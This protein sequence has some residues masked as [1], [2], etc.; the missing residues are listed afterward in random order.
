ML[1]SQTKYSCNTHSDLTRYLFF[2]SDPF[3][4]NFFL[5]PEKVAIVQIQSWVDSWQE[6]SLGL[7]AWIC[8]ARLRR[9]HVSNCTWVWPRSPFD[10]Y[11]TEKTDSSDSSNEDSTA[12]TLKEEIESIFAGTPEPSHRSCCFHL[13]Q[14]R[15]SQTCALFHAGPRFQEEPNNLQVVLWQP[16][17]LQVW[18]RE[19]TD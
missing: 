17:P 5:M 11:Y 8:K 9:K 3:R 13:F 18:E 4:L 12:T 10:A 7:S 14:S 6:K 2:A 16:T 15:V 19:S 1:G